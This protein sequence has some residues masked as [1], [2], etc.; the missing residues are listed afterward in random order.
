MLHPDA[1]LYVVERL[2]VEQVVIEGVKDGLSTHVTAAVG[3][4]RV[5]VSG[6]GPAV[7]D[8]RAPTPERF[9]LRHVTA[10]PARESTPVRFDE[11]LRGS[12][13]CCVLP[14]RASDGGIGDSRRGAPLDSG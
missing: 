14:L 12:A 8:L 11:P 2:P 9:R 13:N 5:T 1:E 6:R 10:L 3:A 7:R 4:R